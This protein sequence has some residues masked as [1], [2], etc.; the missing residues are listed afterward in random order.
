MSLLNDMLRDLSQQQ[1]NRHIMA[2]DADLSLIAQDTLADAAGKVQQQDFHYTS[3]KVMAP[4]DNRFKVVVIVALSLFVFVLLLSGITAIKSLYVQYANNPPV[5]NKT[6][7]SP[8]NEQHS[9]VNADNTQRAENISDS[10]SAVDDSVASI[11]HPAMALQNLNANN[12]AEA[13]QIKIYDLLQAA[14]RAFTMDRLMTPREDNAY[15]YYQQIL[16]LDNNNPAAKKGVVNIAERYLAMADTKIQEADIDRAELLIRR[17]QQVLPEHAP[18]AIYV[19]RLQRLREDEARVLTNANT[20]SL[21]T[22]PAGNHV[23]S[24]L[25]SS[26][27]IGV[28]ASSQS[29]R[30]MQASASVGPASASVSIVEPFAESA[31]PQH[32]SV[33]PNAAW[34]DQQTVTQAQ[35]LIANNQMSAA[36]HLLKNYIQ[37]AEDPVASTRFLLDLYN[38][39][40]AADDMESLLLDA[41]YLPAV[42]RTYYSA[43]L[44]VLKAHRTEAIRLLESRLSEAEDYESYRALLAGLY[45]GEARY[46][47]AVSHYRRLITAFGDKPAYWLGFALS[48]DALGQKPSAL[49][50]YQR[51]DEFSNLQT[52]V[53]QYINQR[54]AELAL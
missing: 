47:E 20:S 14:T 32:L 16:A 41:S 27:E 30:E 34:K 54:I 1:K 26:D 11:N 6:L 53:R 7:S 18:I 45:Q 2:G 36:I 12:N 33:L 48:L 35:D 15:S 43:K 25:L 13:V 37:S 31:A 44:A 29:E 17:A 23:Q 19:E 50:A 51:V 3:T 46:T 8:L 28:E 24:P 4:A 5:A 40:A 38:Q 52:E 21:S 49:Q 10:V 22:A 9:P 39:Q 42:E